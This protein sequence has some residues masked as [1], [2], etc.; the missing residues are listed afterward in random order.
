LVFIV[1]GVIIITF[2]TTAM[3]IHTRAKDDT[4]S[5]DD[6]INKGICQG[7]EK[8]FAKKGITIKGITIKAWVDNAGEIRIKI[9]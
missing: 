2:S 1:I 3:L 5:I 8:G 9:L 6:A 4:I 7:L